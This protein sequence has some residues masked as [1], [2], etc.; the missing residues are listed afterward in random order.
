MPHMTLEYSTNVGAGIDSKQLF[1]IL[2]VQLAK[3]GELR[4]QDFKSRVFPVDT[5]YVG[6]AKD[7]ASFVRLNIE[8]FIGK[9]TQQK[10][11]ISR[12]ALEVLSEYFNEALVHGNCDIAVQ[13]T[14]LEKESY[15]RVRS[16]DLEEKA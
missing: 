11:S 5:F 16:S 2:H 13:I 12:V 14:E 6:L 4:T 1:S 3:A 9:S 15:A 7:N 8:T 10:K